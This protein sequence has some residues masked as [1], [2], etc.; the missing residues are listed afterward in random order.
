MELLQSIL[1]SFKSEGGSNHSP[2]YHVDWML[3]WADIF[4]TEVAYSGGYA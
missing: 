4:R 3:F 1:F 2:L